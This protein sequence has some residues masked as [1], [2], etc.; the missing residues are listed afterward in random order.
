MRRKIIISVSL[1]LVGLLLFLIPSNGEVQESN[2]GGLAVALI[3]DSSG[4][5]K[6]NDPNKVRI[7][8]AKK[9]VAL[10][11][12]N[13]QVTAVE[14]S[15]RASV[16][17]PLKK[18]GDQTSRDEIIS[19]LSAI[20]EKGD[21]DIKGGLESALSELS[22]AEG[23][24]KKLALMLSDGEPDLPALLQDKQKMAAYLADIDK[25]AGEY[26]SR[27]WTVNCVALQKVAAGQTLQKIAQLT[28]GE[29]FFVK[30]AAELTKFFQSILL[31][32]KYSVEEKPELTFIFENKG[33]KVGEK[34]PVNACLKVGKDILIPGPYLKL[35]KFVLTVNYAGQ[36]P[37]F[38]NMMDDGKADSGDQQA[39]DGMFSALADCTLKGEAVLNITAQGSY[40]NVAVNEQV[41]VGKV[42]VKP[43][44][45]TLEKLSMDT[46][47]FIYNNQKVILMACAAM[48]III[49]AII[50]YMRKSRWDMTKIRGSLQYWA[51]RTDESSNPEVLNLAWA[52]KSEILITTDNNPEADF[53]LPLQK[54]PFSMKIK[55]FTGK[56]AN[57]DDVKEFNLTGSSLY[58][59]VICL[60]GIYLVSDG[61]PKSRQQIFNEDQFSIGGYTFK[62]VCKEAKGKAWK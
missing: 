29:Y 23:G 59:W 53:V 5:M 39:G 9:V 52:D 55:K 4:S 25:L 33:Y 42:Q 35:D 24:K 21:T 51:D 61:T 50:L 7:E 32:Q 10:L 37:L 11:G 13:D 48:A 45:S 46:K 12:E 44:Y 31:V 16:L 56:N 30:D 27:G 1:F 20:G 26:K 58:Y 34:I 15:D 28:G 57:A 6:D 40:R 19:K 49:I 14:F 17:I 36:E 47:G 60:P 41:E 62:F 38:I 22:K 3:I 2:T 43:Q 8:A 54:R 18:V